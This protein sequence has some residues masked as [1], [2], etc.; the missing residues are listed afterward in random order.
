M[1]VYLSGPDNVGHGIGQVTKDSTTPNNADAVPYE[2]ALP[3]ESAVPDESGMSFVVFDVTNPVNS[4]AIQAKHVTDRGLS[5]LWTKI[6][7]D[8]YSNAVL[9]ALTADHGQHQ[10]MGADHNT[11]S[12]EGVAHNQ[13]V[14]DNYNVF[15]Q[16]SSTRPRIDI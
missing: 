14:R 8:G 5:R 10:Y 6:Q 3:Y 16:P 4:M 2:T 7:E 1:S 11:E 13:E 9:F 15:T 12:V